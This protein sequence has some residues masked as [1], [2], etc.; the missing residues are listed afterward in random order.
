MGR[1]LKMLRWLGI[2]GVVSAAIACLLLLAGY[3][4]LQTESGRAQ[5]LEMLN[6]QLS[7][8]G[9]TQVRIGRLEGDLPGRIEIRDLSVDDAK[10]TWLRLAYLGANWQP[11]A[12]FAGTISI[13][14]LDADGLTVLRRPEDTQSSEEFHWPE[15]PARIFIE[16][17]LLARAEL[18]SAV[19]G[20]AVAFKASGDTAIEGPDRLRTTI[21]VERTDGI[22]GRAQAQLLLKP[23]SKFLSFQFALNEAD[24]GLL[25]RAMDRD[26]L[27]SLSIQ[28]DGEGPVADVRGNARMRAGGQAFIETSFTIDATKGPAVT[29]AGSA[30]IAKLVEPPLGELLAGALAFAIQ[31]EFIEDGLRL[32]PSSISNALVRLEIDGELSGR[33]ADFDT[34]L[35]ANDLQPLGKVAGLPLHGQLTAHSTIRSDDV[36]RGATLSTTASITQPLPPANSMRAFVGSDV[37]VVGT[38]EF[39]TGRQWAVRD[40][41]VTAD[42]A[43]LT[44]NGTLG[45]DGKTLHGDYRLMIQNLGALSAVLGTPLSGELTVS[46]DFGGSVEDPTLTAQLTSPDLAVD[47]ILLGPARA[48]VDV[49]QF[50]NDVSGRAEVSIDNAYTGAVTLASRFA[51][52][53]K[54]TLRFDGIS[55]KSGDGELQGSM[56]VNLTN[57]TVT[58]ALAGTALPLAPWSKL[59]GQALSGHTS[60]ALGMSSSGDVQ[61]L[62]VTMNAS[63][64]TAALTE[65]RSLD[66]GRI[67]LSARIDDV[68]GVPRGGARAVATD[69][70]TAGARFD[71]VALELETDGPG[72][73]RGK[74]HSR[75]VLGGPFNLELVADYDARENRPVIT[76]SKFDASLSGQAVSLLK[77]A[78]I[79]GDGESTALS[80]STFSVAG[81]RLTAGGRIGADSLDADLS[82]RDISLAALHEVVSFSDVSGTVSG[83]LQVSGTRGAPTGMLDLKVVDVRSTHSTLAVVAP[84]SGH[85]RGDWRDGRL[86]L[87]ATLS[88]VAETRVDARASVPLRLEATSLALSMPADGAIDGALRWSGDLGPVWDLL[89]P[90]EDRFTGPG[91]V[92][93]SLA[94]T[95]GSPTAS[96]HFQV[97]GGHY[98]NV[99]SG[100]TLTNIALRLAG[101]GDRLALEKLT[102]TDGKQGTLA[103][104]GIIDFDP[105]QRYPTNLHLDFQDILLVARD[106]LILNAS[107]KLALQGTLAT[108]LLSGEIVTGQ[109][110]L[111]LAGTLPPQV[112]ELEVNE[113]NAEDSAG[114]RDKAPADGSDPSILILDLDL[115]VPGRAFVRGL[116][117]ESEWQGDLKISGN[118][119]APNIA[120]VLNPVRGHFALLGKRFR[121]EQGDIRFT[122]SDDVDPLLNLTAEHTAS[123]LTALVRVTGSASNPKVSLASRPPLPESEI[124]SQVLFGTDSSNLSAGQSLQLAS[125]I[126]TY[127]GRGGAVGIL[128]A[129]RRALGVD[130]INFAES[131]QDPDKTRLSVG[132][133]VADGVYLEVERGAGDASRVS[134]TVEVEV[135]PDVRIEGGT[136]E[137]GGNQVGVKWKWDY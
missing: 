37:A 68:F 48:R 100:T 126:A 31:G 129:T 3:A 13:T 42:A 127:S 62:D 66:I 40:L 94:G 118:T 58:G 5:L 19:L 27:P 24:G 98:E 89:S 97:T 91:D 57:A 9:S 104:S 112:V 121:L 111:S 64:V 134:T 55:L 6:R 4:F 60:L 131:E 109:S 12:L 45:A 16:H 119:N 102:A 82:L 116:G 135:L 30:H 54:D 46:G 125:A 71:S 39:D 132:K 76:V 107:G 61:R 85:L 114:G 88:E 106:D 1:W 72:R 123:S 7:T 70:K 84:A 77:P 74:L 33:A 81:G 14:K 47:K 101:N 21:A 90:Y 133:Y 105:S 59:A 2:A 49:E 23:Q 41:S 130:V 92:A 17:F 86:Q 75:G 51:G 110:E 87:N 124:A 137:T 113:V 38:V 25:A 83:R 63:G 18:A 95:V 108:A 78:R 122:G 80:K 103:G 29:L 22:S 44:A 26:D 28:V 20:D 73:A 128:D 93:F 11:T 52:D 50:T 69:G 67:A 53:A 56:T 79:E 32:L 115:S 8:P 15:L 36:R 120:G 10:G 117:L 35:T 65:Q 136:T 99:L 96:G 34:T 43:V